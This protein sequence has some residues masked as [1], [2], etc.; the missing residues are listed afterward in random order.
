MG[1]ESQQEHSD[2][3]GE[4]GM[5]GGAGPPSET[6]LPSLEPVRIIHKDQDSITAFCINK[7][8]FLIKRFF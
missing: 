6:P 8:M 2:H 3:G 5:R 1:L 7:V 4:G